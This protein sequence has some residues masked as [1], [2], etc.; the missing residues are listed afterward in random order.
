MENLEKEI[1]ANDATMSPIRLSGKSKAPRKRKRSDA[2]P[3]TAAID[4]AVA[5][6]E[7]SSLNTELSLGGKDDGD[8]LI[9]DDTLSIVVLSEK[10]K[11][12][13]AGHSLP[14]SERQ[15]AESVVGSP[16]QTEIIVTPSEEYIELQSNKPVDNLSNHPESEEFSTPVSPLQN[17]LPKEGQEV[18]LEI[19]N[20]IDQ[21]YSYPAAPK[22][23]KQDPTSKQRN[24]KET[25]GAEQNINEGTK[26][27]L[28]PQYADSQKVFQMLQQAKAGSYT[29]AEKARLSWIFHRFAESGSVSK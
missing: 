3:S 10:D 26:V 25:V 1:A 21:T 20:T 18:K 23:P 22:F 19:P 13:N 15:V 4:S 16:S 6:V 12:D 24:F 17:P 14:D 11:P 7:T 2:I 29:S 28:P 27:S 5:G 9:T 8:R